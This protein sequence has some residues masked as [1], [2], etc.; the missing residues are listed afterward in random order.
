MRTGSDQETLNNYEISFYIQGG[1]RPG[2][3]DPFHVPKCEERRMKVSLE[4]RAVELNVIGV[5]VLYHKS[6]EDAKE[7]KKSLNIMS[8]T[9]T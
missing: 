9:V 6:R 3:E 2:L 4:K 8:S 7:W 5:R 1:K